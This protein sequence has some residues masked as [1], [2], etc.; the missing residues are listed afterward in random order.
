MGFLERRGSSHFS[1]DSS[2]LQ[3]R[4]VLDS[5]MAGRRM[6]ALFTGDLPQSLTEASSGF[7]PR[8]AISDIATARGW[9]GEAWDRRIERGIKAGLDFIVALVMLVLASPLLLAIAIC[10]LADGGSPLYAQT[11][12]GQ[13]GRP[14][15]CLKFR[16]MTHDAEQR[17]R[18]L[19]DSDPIAAAQWSQS[20]KLTWDPRVTKIGWVLRKTSLDELPQLI[21]VL[22]G[23]MSLVGPRPIIAAEIERYGADI[24]SYY[25]VK[26]G[27]TG[28]WQVSG[29]SETTYAHRVQLDVWY[30]DNWSLPRDLSILC[31]TV[32]AVLS[33]RGAA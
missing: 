25:S 7:G 14:F 23:D 24:A 3:G 32:P 4:R 15:R 21:N 26:P 1:D 10:V 33:R 12:I 31:R 20:Q 27:I 29:R 9:P 18:E 11:R 5:G 13:R 30:V 6:S 22:L 17:L 8:S 28:L 19:L 16:T 2:G